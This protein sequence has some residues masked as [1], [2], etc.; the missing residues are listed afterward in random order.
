M[1]LELNDEERH[2]VETALREYKPTRF[3]NGADRSRTMQIVEYLADRVR[4]LCN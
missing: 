1:Q 3:T 4:L 2:I